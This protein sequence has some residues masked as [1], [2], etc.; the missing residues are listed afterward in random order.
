ML[1]GRGKASAHVTE[2][3]SVLLGTVLAGSI[4]ETVGLRA[5]LWVGVAFAMLAAL[6]LAVSPVRAVWRIPESAVEVLG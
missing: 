5:T 4:G 1:V 3:G 2:F 6:A